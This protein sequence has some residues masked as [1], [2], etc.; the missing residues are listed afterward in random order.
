[1][2]IPFK[3]TNI[4]YIRHWSYL[5]TQN[6]RMMNGKES[7][8]NVLLVWTSLSGY[9]RGSNLLP[10]FEWYK[11]LQLN[12][13]YSILALLN[14]GSRNW[15]T[16]SNIQF[17]L[18]YYKMRSSQSPSTAG[19]RLFSRHSWQS[20]GTLSTETGIT[21]SSYLVSN[22]LIGHILVWI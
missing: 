14:A 22:H 19:H 20:Q 3:I 17:S 21:V 18:P 12:P 2:M 1:M 15:S 8:L 13:L 11:R 10:W 16:R 4:L 6:S 9:L 5:I 7:R